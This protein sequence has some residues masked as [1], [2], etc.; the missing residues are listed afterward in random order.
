MGIVEGTTYVPA[1]GIIGGSL[2][3]HNASR[4]SMARWLTL[5][6]FVLL[7]WGTLFAGITG[8]SDE[9]LVIVNESSSELV[10]R[11]RTGVFAGPD[12]QQIVMLMKPMHSPGARYTRIRKYW[13][14]TQEHVSLR[15]G[16]LT[17]SISPGGG[18]MVGGVWRAGVADEADIVSPHLEI[19]GPEKKTEYDGVEVFSAFDRHSKGL[20]MLVVK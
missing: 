12:F 2:P 14:L 7:A 8:G 11:Y 3:Q 20:R 15:D 13:P 5:C 6:L 10:V 16:M 9:Y 17:F 4:K 1:A 18:V 19:E